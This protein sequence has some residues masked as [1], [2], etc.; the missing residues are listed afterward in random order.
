MSKRKIKDITWKDVTVDKYM[1]LELIR[2]MQNSEIRKYID[3]VGLFYEIEDP[4]EMTLEEYGKYIAHL[5]GI[6]ELP[7]RAERV[8]NEVTI[9]GKKFSRL[10]DVKNMSGGQ[11]IDFSVKNSGN[12]FAEILAVLYQNKDMNFRERMNW[13]KKYETI[14]NAYP[15]LSFFLTYLKGSLKVFQSSLSLKRKQRRTAPTL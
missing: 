11:F 15:Y 1:K 5:G 8:T 2:K 3:I 6:A 12:N 13:I 14:D 9:N 4:L 10:V 7:K